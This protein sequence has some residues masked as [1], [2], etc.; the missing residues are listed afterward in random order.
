M[1]EIVSIRKH[2]GDVFS[3]EVPDAWGPVMLYKRTSRGGVSIHTESGKI[4]VLNP[5]ASEASERWLRGYL[6]DEQARGVTEVQT[7]E[8]LRKVLG[9]A[10]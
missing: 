7:A 4:L 9:A 1:G 2:D 3:V 6:A 8:M 5:E 10:R